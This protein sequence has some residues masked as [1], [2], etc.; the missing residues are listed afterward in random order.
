MPA[1][2]SP[3]VEAY[4]A[5]AP[6]AQ[7]EPLRALL[8]TIRENIPDGFHEQMQYGMPAWVVPHSLYPAGY[9]CD[10]K[11]PLP[12]IG[13]AARAKNV[14]FYHMGMYAEGAALAAFQ[15]AWAARVGRKLDMGKSCVRIKVVD[16]PTLDVI[17]E[18]C[19]R[20]TPQAWI[21]TYERA[22]RR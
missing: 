7:Q 18:A 17:A 8:A 21:E 3:D 12:F 22:L 15:D 19:R 13:A 11:Q 14:T 16:A 10:T 9:H 6:E 1:A 2:A 4:A 5:A 20:T